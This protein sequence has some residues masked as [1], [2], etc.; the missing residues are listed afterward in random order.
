MCFSSKGQY[1]QVHAD[2]LRFLENVRKSSF[3]HN[4]VHKS[5]IKD[6]QQCK[7]TKYMYSSTILRVTLPMFNFKMCKQ[8]YNKSGLKLL[9]SPQEAACNLKTKASVAKLHCG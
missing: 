3:C 8:D 5:N 7:V 9:V 1:A 2:S 6:K 4:D